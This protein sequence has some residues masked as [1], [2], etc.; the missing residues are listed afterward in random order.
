MVK[1][2]NTP[3]SSAKARGKRPR[4]NAVIEDEDSGVDLET[5]QP[6]TSTPSTTTAANQKSQTKNTRNLRDALETHMMYLDEPRAEDRNANFLARV[7]AILKGDRSSEKSERS[8]NAIKESQH[9]NRVAMENTYVTA[10]LPQLIGTSRTVKISEETPTHQ[11]SSS[12]PSMSE[13]QSNSSNPNVLSH[14][15]PVIRSFAEDRLHWEGPC[16]FVKEL[17]T[18]PRTVKLLGITDPQP[19]IGFGIRKRGL[20]FNPPILSDDTK[21]RIHAAGPLDFCFFIIE[22]KGPDGPFAHAVTQAIRGGATLVR[23]M[24]D[25]RRRAGYEP[26]G[27]GADDETFVFTCAWEHGRADI[28]ASWLE[29]LPEGEVTH[30]TWLDSYALLKDRDLKEF[31][32]DLHNI[33]DWGIDPN[34]IAKLEQMVSDTGK[35]EAAGML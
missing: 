8:V 24:R 19:D 31:C 3:T 10:V 20:V 28:F 12:I 14:M 2:P 21:N 7:R 27:I 18:G 22:D 35:R 1:A 9:A 4:L 33:L 16:Y 15:K 17:I 25:L 34:R 30:M 11:L 5:S 32:R 29:V 23:V 6:A 13:I 26:S